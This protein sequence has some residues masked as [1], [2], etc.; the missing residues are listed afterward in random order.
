MRYDSNDCLSFSKHDDLALHSSM[1]S[2]AIV[3]DY[4][5]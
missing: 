4:C 5:S 2:V 3:G 1:I